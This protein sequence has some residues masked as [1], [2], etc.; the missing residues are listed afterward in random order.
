M[1]F[2]ATYAVGPRLPF[3]TDELPPV[4][5]PARYVQLRFGRCATCGRWGMLD[6]ES[7]VCLECLGKEKAR[8]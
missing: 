4:S 5:A 3:I 8:R 1:E 6:G 2:Q 7:Y